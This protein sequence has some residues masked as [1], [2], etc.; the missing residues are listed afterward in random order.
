MAVPP[1]EVLQGSEVRNVPIEERQT[2][3]QAEELIKAA[4]AGRSFLFGLVTIW[5]HL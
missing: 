3:K 4:H 5:T 1:A 2:D